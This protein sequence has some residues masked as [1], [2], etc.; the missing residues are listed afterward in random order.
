[1]EAAIESSYLQD[2]CMFFAMG[3]TVHIPE[4]VFLDADH[5]VKLDGIQSISVNLGEIIGESEGTLVQ[6]VAALTL[7]ATWLV[8]QF[9]NA[10]NDTI[11][12]F[13]FWDSVLAQKA[14]RDAWVGEEALFDAVFAALTFQL[15]SPN[16]YCQLSALHGLNHLRHPRT[17][18]VVD[19]ALGP[20]GDEEVRA[21][22][23]S[24][25]RFEAM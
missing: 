12:L 6:R 9:A 17:A 25:K 22:A 15:V 24:A 4:S 7:A 23:A 5:S 16:R 14:D 21:Y 10:T 19:A 13:G 1:L 20:V 18:W 8:R 11:G 3:P 2:C